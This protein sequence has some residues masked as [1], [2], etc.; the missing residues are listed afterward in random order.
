MVGLTPN[1]D[2]LIPAGDVA[3]L[4]EW[5]AEIRR[6]FGTPL[7]Q[8]SAVGKQKLSL[9]LD[10]AQP[11]NYYQIQEDITK[12][13]RIRAYRVEARVDG[14]WTAVAKGSSVGHKR[15]EAFPETNAREFRL[16]VEQSTAEP[17]IRDFS[18]FSVKL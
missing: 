10:K 6:R 7:A 3:R 1:P 12:G 11:V 13:E 18:I 9:K 15:I 8:T 17:Q 16:V 5:G 14:K 2:G 4:Q